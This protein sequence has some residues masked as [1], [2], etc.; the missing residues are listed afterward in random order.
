MITGYE[1]FH[2]LLNA[3]RKARGCEPTIDEMADYLATYLWKNPTLHRSCVQHKEIIAAAINHFISSRL[4]SDEL[5]E[6]GRQ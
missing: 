6:R 1:I 5:L 4:K 3:E 2:T